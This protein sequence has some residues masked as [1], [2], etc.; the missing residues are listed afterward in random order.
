MPRRRPFPHQVAQRM[1][2]RHH[3]SP[4]QSQGRRMWCTMM[5]ALLREPRDV[6][7]LLFLLSIVFIIILPSL[8]C[9]CSL[10]LSLCLFNTCLSNVTHSHVCFWH[11][12]PLRR[13]FASL[14]SLL[15]FDYCYFVNV[16][17]STPRWAVQL[18]HHHHYHHHSTW[19]SR[20]LCVY[21]CLCCSWF[22]FLSSLDGEHAASDISHIETAQCI[23][24]WVSEREHCYF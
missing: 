19:F 5:E 1:C 6:E 21:I 10:S 22:W 23:V 7:N 11:H 4:L 12:L 17:P 9:V 14:S 13:S 8:S 24:R 3:L 15:K 18:V 16:S 2:L 20:S